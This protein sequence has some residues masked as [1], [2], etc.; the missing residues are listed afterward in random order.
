MASALGLVKF[1]PA[2]EMMAEAEAAEVETIEV[3]DPLV[4][5]DG[6]V[7]YV[8]ECWDEALRFKQ[9]NY[10]Q[11]FVR[12]MYSRRGEYMPG[13]LFEIH[14]RGGSDEYARIVANKSR[15]LESWLK[16]IFLAQGERPWTIEATP[17]PTLP[18][19]TVEDIRTEVSQWM[20]QM[21]AMGQSVSETD[22]MRLMDEKIDAERTR[23][24]D[25][26][27]LRAKRME[28]LIADQLAEGGFEG[29]FSE[30]IAYLTTYPGA[31]FKG[32]I[33]RRRERITWS[34]VEGTYIPEVTYEIVE[35]FEAVNPLNAYPAPGAES[36]QEGFFIEHSTITA[37]DL[38]DLIGVEGYDEVRI[39]RVLDKSERE[40]GL[41][42][43]DLNTGAEGG[44]VNQH[45]VRHSSTETKYIDMLEFHGSISGRLLDEWG[46]EGVDGDLQKYYEATVWLIDTEVI[47]AVLNDD[48]MGRR[49]YYK[50]CYEHIPGQFWGYSMY[51]VLADV[52]GVCN[53]AIRSLVNN[54]AIASGPQCIV[55]VDRLPPGEDITNLYPW[56]IWQINDSQFGNT[57]N[58]AIDFFQPNTNVQDLLAVLEKFYALADDFSMIPRYM[59]GSDKVSGPARTASGLSMLLDSAN[60]GLKSIVQSIDQHVVSPLLEQ[61]FDHNMIYSDDETIKGDSQVV[62]RGVASLMQLETLRM[63]RNEFLQITANPIDSQI[64][65]LDGRAAILREIAKTLGMDVNKIIPPN[66]GQGTPAQPMPQ[67]EMSEMPG[68][69]QAPAPSGEVLGNG[70]PVTDVASPS[71]M[72]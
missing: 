26:A 57:S 71:A 1:T 15:I 33:F 42:W 65:G 39:R 40:G 37:K 66:V 47:K 14:Q 72:V 58:P 50:A 4:F 41:R 64:V 5:A 51:D 17:N 20:A 29:A 23:L 28:S 19:D 22:A 53:A 63:R 59:S 68:G 30:F 13:K 34:Q 43:I 27:T 38:Y 61:M 48:P 46:V 36:P 12:A 25:V 49:P 9:Q 31:V 8:R 69:Q 6:I 3:V 10:E 55:N 70:A 54:M 11:R 67:Q 18:D 45:T 16:D 32:P 24:G 52:E 60:K 2:D 21:V 62:A 44:E 7:R 35:E 56:K